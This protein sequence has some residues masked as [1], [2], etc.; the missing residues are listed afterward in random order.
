MARSAG[1]RELGQDPGEIV[2]GDADVRINEPDGRVPVAPIRSPLFPSRTSLLDVGDAAIHRHRC[3]FPKR[4]ELH[5]TP[6]IAGQGELGLIEDA[7]AL[8]QPAEAGK[9]GIWRSG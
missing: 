9:C 2:R 5:E 8:Q 3:R 6:L 1:D 7:M 4:Q